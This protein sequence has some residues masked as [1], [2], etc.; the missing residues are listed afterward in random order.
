MQSCVER[1]YK[2]RVKWTKVQVTER[3]TESRW[4]RVGSRLD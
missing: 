1:F 3:V 4:H 2:V